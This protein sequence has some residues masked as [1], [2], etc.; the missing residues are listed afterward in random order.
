M[1]LI[2]LVGAI[3]AGLTAALLPAIGLAGTPPGRWQGAA[4]PV[5]QELLVNRDFEA[6][7]LAPWVGTGAVSLGPGRG[8]LGNGAQFGG[9]DNAVGELW[10][11]VSIPAGAGPVGLQFW[12]LAESP[13]EQLD[14]YLS[15]CLAA[16]PECIPVQIL[17]AVPPFG[18]WRPEGVNVTD[19]AGQTVKVLFS[20]RTNAVQPSLFR[21]DDVSL[22][23]CGLQPPTP[24]AHVYI[25]LVLRES[26]SLP[27]Q[28]PVAT[29]TPT[30]TTPTPSATPSPTGAPTS[31][32]TG[33]PTWTPTATPGALIL[34]A[35][36]NDGQLAGWTANHGTWSNPGTYMQGAYDSDT[37]WNIHSASASNLVY[38]G[39]VS[40]LSGNAVGLSFRSS[41]DGTSS[42]DVILD[43]VQNLFKI[44]KRSP[45]RTLA[46]DGVTLE[47]NHAYRIKVVANGNTIEAYLDGVKRLTVTDSTYTSGQLGVMLHRGTASYD[48][49]MAWSTP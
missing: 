25:P 14:D 1:N 11:E 49:L 43:V 39:T 32:P 22:L 30:T 28:T 31:A 36:F 33:T 41:A 7:S 23:A 35:D 47:R 21:L 9:M 40:I 29:L 3:L 48:D 15:I 8:A 34:T 37:A 42:Y 19:H 16:G 5:C 24:G 2:L 17:R 13:A 38:E 10:Q 12:W 20:V 18:V 44:S 45:Y 26:P 27:T 46:W 6:G 4:L